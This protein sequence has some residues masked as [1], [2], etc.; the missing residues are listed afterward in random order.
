M[1]PKKTAPSEEQKLTEL[2]GQFDNTLE[3]FQERITQLELALEDFSWYR[4]I[5]E[6]QYEFSRQGLRMISQMARIMFLKNPL[7]SRGVKITSYYVFGQGVTINSPDPEV[8]TVIQDFIRD[9]KNRAELTRQE[10]MTAKEAELEVQGNLFFVFF[11]NID[12]GRVIIRSISLEQILEIVT[13]PEDRKDPWYYLRQWTEVGINEQGT[14][15]TTP[16]E[17]YYPDWLYNPTDKPPT[18]GGKKV[19]W[20]TP[21][22]HK[23]IGALPDMKFGL[24]EFYAAQDWAKAYTDFLQAWSQ[25]TQSLARFAWKRKTKDAKTLAMEKAK[26]G[27]TISLNS[28][29]TNPPPVAGATALMVDGTDLEPIKTSGAQAS[30]EDG[31]RLLLMAA[32]V[33]GLPETFFGDVSVGTLATANSLDRPTELK[34]RDRQTFWS[35]TFYDILHY[36][37]IQSAKATSGKLKGKITVDKAEDGTEQATMPDGMPVVINTEWPPILEHATKD[38]IMAIMDATTLGAPGTPAGTID[39]E[40]VTRLLCQ[41]L[42]VKDVDGVLAALKDNVDQTNALNA[43]EAGLA[44]AAKAVRDAVKQLK[45]M[46]APAH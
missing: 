1:T 29:E 32:A 38:S 19:N 36:A 14:E 45:E 43:E 31:R 37:V 18:I 26:L 35:D 24:C 34:F 12:T 27:T 5:G 10:A 28:I 2:Q 11:T 8:N 9:S 15:T 3:F 22:Y 42:G 40:T 30:M 41:A 46:Y 23:K 6:S 13:N 20:D 16:R 39:P 21:I 44:E 33:F 4:I 7:I 17:E 25:I